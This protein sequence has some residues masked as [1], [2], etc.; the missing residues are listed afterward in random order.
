M[1][2]NK[3]LQ[4]ENKVYELPIKQQQQQKSRDSGINVTVTAKSLN[5]S[6]IRV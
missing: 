4:E 6:Y 2:N 5:P 1:E 3:P